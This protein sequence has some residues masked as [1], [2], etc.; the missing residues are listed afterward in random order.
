M[1]QWKPTTQDNSYSAK[2]PIGP[3]RRLAGFSS[4]SKQYWLPRSRVKAPTEL[5]LTTPFSWCYQALEEFET[6]GDTLHPTALGFIHF[7][8]ELNQIFL[9]DAAA[10]LFHKPD[11]KTHPLYQT[12]P[13]LQSEAFKLFAIEMGE[14]LETMSQN[15][16]FDAN[17]E[18]VMPGIS[19]WHRNTHGAINLLNTKQAEI[20]NKQA[21]IASS[22]FDF[23]VG[24]LNSME[25]RMKSIEDHI[26]SVT[27]RQDIKDC[28]VDMLGAFSRREGT[29]GR[30]PEL[31]W[32]PTLEQS[33]TLE[34]TF[35]LATP[36]TCPNP[37][38]GF[39]SP[40]HPMDTS[41]LQPMDTSPPQPMDTDNAEST[42]EPSEIHSKFMLR[43]KHQS[44]LTMWE[45][46]HGIDDFADGYG[47]VAGRDKRYGNKWRKHLDNNSYS[48]NKRIIAGI[49]KHS[50]NN[51]QNPLISIETQ[52]D[53]IF[54]NHCNC[55]PQRMVNYMQD[56]GLVPKR[57]NR[58]RLARI[59]IQNHQQSN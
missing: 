27:T 35:Q 2:L 32:P 58:G 53:N 55:S 39:V 12:L 56:T 14:H 37:R 38:E 18:S 11:R 22:R 8:C 33:P 47:G 5:L 44:L 29:L 51:R 24:S 42:T 7:I 30:A 4:Q 3:I 25:D 10:L 20:A 13:C 23:I 50:E 1:G 45:E 57:K 54:K 36:L 15:S 9:Q 48:R 28:L 6:R 49:Q 19:E 17:L 46:W 16:P 34:S 41:P 26:S 52:L 31:Q 21:E 43:P 59:H 40:P